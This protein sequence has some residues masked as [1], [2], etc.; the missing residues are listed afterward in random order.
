KR[1]ARV[2]DAQNRYLIAG[3]VD[4]HVHTRDPRLTYKEDFHALTRA[5]AAGGV[6]TLV[7]VPNMNPLPNTASNY[8]AKMKDCKTRAVVDFNHWALPTNLSEIDRIAEL[9]AVGFKFFMVPSTGE[10]STIPYPPEISIL[11][12]GQIMRVFAAISKTGLPC[13]VHPLEPGIWR[14]AEEE[15]SEKDGRC[16]L[17]VELDGYSYRESLTLTASS[18]ALVMIANSCKAKLQLAQVCSKPQLELA[19]ALKNGG[20]KFTTELNPF[21]LF[22]SSEDN[23]RLGTFG[24]GIYRE[25]E[26]RDSLYGFLRDGTVDIIT[27]GHAPHTREDLKGESNSSDSPIPVIQDYLKL[28]LDAVNKGKLSLETLVRLMCENP[29]KIAQFFPTKGTI[30][31]GSDADLVILDMKKRYKISN[32]M[33]YSKSGWTPWDG[34][35]VQGSPE[36][37]FVRGKE[38]MGDY[39]SVI[40]SKGYGEFVRPTI[41]K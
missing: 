6:T 31:V 8:L 17:D 11:D 32:D 40:G 24:R 28:F 22:L 14:E 19:R 26:E 38:V 21:A 36:R 39:D 23:K 10:K 37:V 34:L 12:Y 27:T 33:P 15:I 13:A 29:A 35:E 1:A 2:I 20:Y 30:E 4:L 9:G 25:G 41:A 5:A 16:N 7:D 3:L 18:A